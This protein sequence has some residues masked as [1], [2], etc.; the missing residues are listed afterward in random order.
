M[1]GALVL[2]A[3]GMWTAWEVGAWRVLRHRF[4]PDLIVDDPPH[5]TF[6]GEDAQLKGAV[7]HLLRLIKDQPVPAASAP[8]RPD[9]T[10]R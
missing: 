10:P 7:D 6:Q 3:G 2:S 9:K 8:K 5:A 4:E 1:T